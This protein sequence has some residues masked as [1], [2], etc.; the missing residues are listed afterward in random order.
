M[1]IVAYAVHISSGVTPEDPRAMERFLAMGD[2]IPM[3]FAVRR[4][5]STPTSFRS[6]MVAR[7]RDLARASMSGMGPRKVPS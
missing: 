4:T 2:W 3:A 1:A 6:L 5:G 7:L